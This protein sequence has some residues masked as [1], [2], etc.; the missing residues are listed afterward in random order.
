MLEHLVLI[1]GGGLLFFCFFLFFSPQMEDIPL[2]YSILFSLIGDSVFRVGSYAAR[3][4]VLLPN[5][6][7]RSLARL[8]RCEP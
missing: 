1:T 8:I 3:S 7:N 2:F 6:L 5:Y 4:N